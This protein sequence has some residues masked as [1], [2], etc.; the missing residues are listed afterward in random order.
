MAQIAFL[1]ADRHA[2]AEERVRGLG[3]GDVALFGGSAVAVYVA[4][5]FRGQ[6]GIRQCHFHRDP[7][8]GGFRPSDVGA[9]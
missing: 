3:F 5:G 6:A 4:D 7:H 9:V 2:A 1:R 8:G